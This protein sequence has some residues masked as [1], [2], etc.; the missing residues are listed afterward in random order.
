MDLKHNT[1]K[2]LGPQKSSSHSSEMELGPV[3]WLCM[4]LGQ[5][6]SADLTDVITYESSFHQCEPGNVSDIVKG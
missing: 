6:S 2:G 3:C 4:V 5:S 1:L